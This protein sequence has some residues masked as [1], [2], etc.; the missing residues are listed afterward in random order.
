MYDLLYTYSYSTLTCPNIVI[1]EKMIFF[2]NFYCF[3]KE[4]QASEHFCGL[5]DFHINYP[6][7]LVVVLLAVLTKVVVLSSTSIVLVYLSQRLPSLV[8]A[9]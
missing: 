6:G 5:V 7:R 1:M 9:S 2:I 3:R 4:S 8:D